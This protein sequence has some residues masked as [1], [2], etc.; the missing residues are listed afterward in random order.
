MSELEKPPPTG[1]GGQNPPDPAPGKT[2]L[3][4]DNVWHGLAGGFITVLLGVG[5]GLSVSEDYYGWLIFLGC[6]V[7]FMARSF[8][9]KRPRFILG[10]LLAFGISAVLFVGGCFLYFMTHD[11]DLR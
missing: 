4:Y 11:L 3:R 2:T 10:V 1:E 8:F 6:F 9:I 5:V 7:I